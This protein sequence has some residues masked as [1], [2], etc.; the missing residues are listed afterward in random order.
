M[1][2][3]WATNLY[4][5]HDLIRHQITKL[6]VTPTSNHVSIIPLIFSISKESGV[7]LFLIQRTIGLLAVKCLMDK[8]SISAGKMAFSTNYNDETLE[9]SK[10]CFLCI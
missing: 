3:W 4:G 8:F 10:A 9:K 2:K 5:R 6:K 1:Y 7:S